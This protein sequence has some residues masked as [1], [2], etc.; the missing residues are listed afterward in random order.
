MLIMKINKADLER[1][2]FAKCK[3]DRGFS[4]KTGKM[5]YRFNNKEWTECPLKVYLRHKDILI[6]KEDEKPKDE[7]TKASN[8]KAGK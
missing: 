8:K 5:M 7:L 4:V 3:D 6:L 1:P 2:V